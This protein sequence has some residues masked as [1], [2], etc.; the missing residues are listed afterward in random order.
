MPNYEIKF[1]PKSDLELTKNIEISFGEK[2][3]V[4]ILTLQIETL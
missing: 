2:K 4:N 1:T 3:D